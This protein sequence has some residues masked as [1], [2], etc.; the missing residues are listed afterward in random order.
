MDNADE[1]KKATKIE[2]CIRW[3]CGRNNSNYRR[4]RRRKRSCRKPCKH[5]CLQGRLLGHRWVAL[6]LVA[7]SLCLQVG[8]SVASA[9]RL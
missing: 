4:T 3:G 1:K 5:C 7:L 9:G 8:S 6:S 2:P